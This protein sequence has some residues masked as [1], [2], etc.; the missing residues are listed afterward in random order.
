ML[1]C[2]AETLQ[3]TIGLSCR[4]MLWSDF[5]AKRRARLGVLEAEFLVHVTSPKGW[6]AALCKYNLFPFFWRQARRSIREKW[7]SLPRLRIG[8]LDRGPPPPA[9]LEHP[10]LII[11][12]V[13]RPYA[14]VHRLLSIWKWIPA[15]V[16]EL[17][18]EQHRGAPVQMQFELSGKSNPF[19]RGV[20]LG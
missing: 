11:M 14:Q 3:G 7:P 18:A 20:G 10:V 4:A 9:G 19:P 13:R 2:R 12:S 16:A 8:S 6:P 5:N 15:L 1:C 17:W